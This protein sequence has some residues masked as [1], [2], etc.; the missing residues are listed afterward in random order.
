M[1]HARTV[2]SLYK[3]SVE[4]EPRAAQPAPGL[5]A[6]SVPDSTASADATTEVIT[7]RR[8]A[9][10]SKEELLSAALDDAAKTLPR[11]IV[12]VLSAEIPDV[13][14]PPPP[15]EK[16]A[17]RRPQLRAAQLRTAAWAP[18]AAEMTDDGGGSGG[19]TGAAAVA[20]APAASSAAQAQRARRIVHQARQHRV[21][22]AKSAPQLEREELSAELIAAFREAMMATEKRLTATMVENGEL[23]SLLKVARAASSGDEGRGE[24][25]PAA[26]SAPQ[27]P[28]S[29]PPEVATDAALRSQLVE[30]QVEVRRLELRTRE[31][32]GLLSRAHAS[33]GER[34]A[35]LEELKKEQRAVQSSSSSSSPDREQWY[36]EQLARHRTEEAAL[37][38]RVATAEAEAA[39]A[40]T[41][42]LR[43]AEVSLLIVSHPPPS[44][45]R[46]GGE[47]G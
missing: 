12:E 24:A 21:N 25:P 29:S 8:A 32:Q 40:P 41:L 19:S 20:S 4:H 5:P 37:Q 13:L 47:A 22:V 23:H 14:P 17:V 44:E 27:H 35:Q 28:S 11:D 1:S 3:K 33:E 45:W 30:R 43:V 38:A 18:T 9:G 39:A 6:Q 34:L 42:R 46:S 10:P 15:R 16:N 2:D 7:A 31:L 26:A 36:Q